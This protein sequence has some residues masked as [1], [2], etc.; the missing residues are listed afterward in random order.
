MSS[1]RVF[2]IV[3]AARP[4]EGCSSKTLVL[5]MTA[6]VTMVGYAAPKLLPR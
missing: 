5:Q 3:I 4:A 2:M 6:I 1:P